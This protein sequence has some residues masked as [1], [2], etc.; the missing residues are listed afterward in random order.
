MWNHFFGFGWQVYAKNKVANILFVTK[1]GGTTVKY[2]PLQLAKGV[3]DLK[4]LVN[5]KKGE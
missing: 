3:F 1:K 4:R 5:N 2:R